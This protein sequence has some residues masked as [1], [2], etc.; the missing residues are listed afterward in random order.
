LQASDYIQE[1][2]NAHE[3]L[4]KRVL[5]LQDNEQNMVSAGYDR[6]VKIW[7]A[8]L[9]KPLVSKAEHPFPIEA[10][11]FG[12]SKD[13]LVVGSGNVCSVW[14]LRKDFGE[15]VVMSCQPHLKPIL[16]LA[17]D[18]VRDRIITGAADTMLKFIDPTVIAILILVRKVFVCY[19]D[20]I[21]TNSI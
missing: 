19:K 2:P 7:D 21:T 11:T 5:Y 13:Q 15:G 18:V 6:L 9:D 4:V 14:D 10:I 3:D 16:A 1:I 8:R 20:G 12:N 17:Y